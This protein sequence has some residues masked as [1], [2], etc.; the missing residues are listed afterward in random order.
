MTSGCDARVHENK[1]RLSISV[2]IGQIGSDRHQ[3]F[4]RNNI[5]YINLPFY[6]L[7]SE[8]HQ[9]FWCILSFFTTSGNGQRSH[10]AKKYGTRKVKVASR[11]FFI[12]FLV[13]HLGIP[14]SGR[15]PESLIAGS[16]EFGTCSGCC[17]VRHK[18]DTMHVMTC[19]NSLFR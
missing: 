12:T 16:V 14:V 4:T 8:M 19:L 1:E 10:D 9:S 18:T 11:G 5:L 13:S 2:I 7:V 17:H 6:A 3:T 15:S